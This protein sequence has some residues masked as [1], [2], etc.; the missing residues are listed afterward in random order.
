[1]KKSPDVR[2]IRDENGDL[3]AQVWEENAGTV[4]RA[5]KCRLG[6][7]MKELIDYPETWHKLSDR[8]LYALCKQGDPLP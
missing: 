6:G 7:E 2:E 3:I 1:M 8:K 5:L 4:M